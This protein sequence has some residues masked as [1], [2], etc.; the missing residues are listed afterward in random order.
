[1]M[2]SLSNKDDR[3][4]SQALGSL[5]PVRGKQQHVAI[6]GHQHPAQQDP[7]G[8][9]RGQGEHTKLSPSPLKMDSVG[10]GYN[11]T[12]IPRKAA[13]PRLSARHRPPAPAASAAAHPRL[14]DLP[15]GGGNASKSEAGQAAST[16]RRVKVKPYHTGNRQLFNLSLLRTSTHEWER[17]K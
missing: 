16:A 3:G 13:V 6:A 5:P 11:V 14:E 4:T 10:F 9:R 15:D 7:S 12:P 2:D 17:D 8:S 1:M